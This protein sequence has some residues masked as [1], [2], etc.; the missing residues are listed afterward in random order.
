[1]YRYI[2]YTKKCDFF[3]YATHLY[4][5]FVV[6][7]SCSVFIGTLM[8]TRSFL[9]EIRTTHRITSY[10]HAL[11]DSERKIDGGGE[12]GDKERESS[13]Q[14]HRETDKWREKER[15][16]EGEEIKVDSGGLLVSQEDWSGFLVWTP[17][18]GVLFA[19]KV[20]SLLVGHHNTTQTKG[21][22]VEFGF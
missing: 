8:F 5:E 10:I 3:Q 6:S 18:V 21:S 17:V 19:I 12:R 1:M 4:G 22:F 15:N 16:M 2:Q 20:Q 11:T 9:L 7:C 14:A 13:W